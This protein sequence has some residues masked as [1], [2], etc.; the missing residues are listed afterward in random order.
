MIRGKVP[1]DKMGHHRTPER[2]RFRRWWNGRI[3]LLFII[4]LIQKLNL[5]SPLYKWHFW[6]QLTILVSN[7]EH[8]SSCYWTFHVRN[9]CPH[10]AS[11]VA[12]GSDTPSDGR[13]E[14]PLCSSWTVA[15]VFGARGSMKTRSCCLLYWCSKHAYEDETKACLPQNMKGATRDNNMFVNSES[16]E[17][18][19]QC[20]VC[21]LKRN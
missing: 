9:K 7:N 2:E 14:L 21:R 17:G 19:L 5:I 3:G 4:Y 16:N 15:F 20:W 1:V 12:L 11:R 18:V 10:L 8:N 13:Y 6:D